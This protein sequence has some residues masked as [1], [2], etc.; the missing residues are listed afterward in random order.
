MMLKKQMKTLLVVAFALAFVAC[1]SSVALA[2]AV[3]T[4]DD[5]VKCHSEQPA[6]IAANGASHKTEINCQECHE[7]HRPSSENN[8]PNCNDCHDGSAHYEVE[9]A[10]L[11]C[12]N[13]HQ[14]LNVT[15][16]GE[17]K[18]VCISCHAGPNKQMVANP[19]KHATFACNFCHADTHGTIPDCV[20]CHEPHSEAVTQADCATC[21]KPHKPLELMYPPS[22]ASTLCA[23]CHG[24]PHAASMH[25]RFPK[26]GECHNIAH[27]LNNWP[28]K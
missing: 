13:P 22:T 25:E 8:I 16:E 24:Q 1:M 26:C 12:H 9:V 14:P 4:V 11:S 19:S 21:H 3:L 23:A 2:E 27:D 10:C 7:G 18:K 5:C 6:Q 15:L 20:D 28:A 17:H